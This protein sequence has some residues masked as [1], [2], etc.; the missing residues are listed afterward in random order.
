MQHHNLVVAACLTNMC[1]GSSFVFV[2]H[3]DTKNRVEVHINGSSTG[4]RFVHMHVDH[5]GGDNICCLR[6]YWFYWLPCVKGLRLVWLW[7]CVVCSLR[8]HRA[9][10]L[11]MRKPEMCLTKSI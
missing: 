2:D 5:K 1:T 4:T 6:V 3:V 8:A 7:W 10:K 9:C 11:L